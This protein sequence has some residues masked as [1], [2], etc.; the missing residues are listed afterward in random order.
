M[1]S[2]VPLHVIFLPHS[3]CSLCNGS[4]SVH[5]ERLPGTPKVLLTLLS[6]HLDYKQIMPSFLHR[7]QD[8]NSGPCVCVAGTSAAES[9]P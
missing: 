1:S 2:S 7:C 3:L 6:E 9:L 5:P 4:S 8:P